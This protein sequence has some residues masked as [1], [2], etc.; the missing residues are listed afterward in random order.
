MNIKTDTMVTIIQSTQVKISCD[1]PSDAR[2]STKV[3]ETFKIV[4]RLSDPMVQC[5]GVSIGYTRCCK[6]KLMS[7]SYRKHIR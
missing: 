6:Y 1:M 4:G 5:T 7:P 2:G 3:I